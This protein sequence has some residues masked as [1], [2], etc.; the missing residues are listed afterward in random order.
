MI[1]PFVI[2]IAGGSGSGKTTF[3]KRLRNLFS[4]DDV[5]L[6]SQD[7]Y[8]KKRDEQETDE[9][10]QKNFDLPTSFREHDFIT[11]VEKLINGDV[12]EITEYTF[13]NAL[14]E[15]RTIEYKPAKVLIIEGLF[16]YHFKEIANLMDLKIFVD[17][18][19]HLKLIRRIYR[20]QEERN[21]PLDDVL[22]RYEKH[23]FPSFEKY[24]L[25]YKKECDIVLNNN[26][27]KNLERALEVMSAFIKNKI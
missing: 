14:A 18:S 19:S 2:G 25:P 20:D 11:D 3:V 13:N 15:T 23:V 16:V 27:P 1:K 24:I 17:V 22:Y 5:C 8:Y 12:V 4:E 26:T 6:L 10:N 21:Y 9:N 7:N